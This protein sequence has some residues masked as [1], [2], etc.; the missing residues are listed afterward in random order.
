MKKYNYFFYLFLI[1][2]ISSC[3]E[4]ND[5]NVEKSIQNIIKKFPQ[6][7]TTNKIF[8]ND[9]K[10]VKSVKNGE[11]DFE[12]QL[13][14]EPDIIEDKQQIIVLINS[15]KEC[16]SIPFFSNKYKDYWKFPFDKPINNTVKIGSTFK[17]ELNNALS[18][19]PEPKES[20]NDKNVKYE[21]V[22]EMLQSLLVTKNLE[23]KDSL[24]IYRTLFFN[25]NIPNELSDSV[26]VRLHKN[27]DKM[28]SEWHPKD[29]KMTNYNCYYDIKNG[30]IY[31]LN[32]NKKNKGYNVKCY[33]QDKGFTPIRL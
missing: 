13:F 5:K 25:S 8:G 16:T 23:E 4:K 18:I 2:I 3:A 21:V 20:I 32:Y 6:L 17:V 10:L 1:I 14:S 11:F 26:L 28:K 19:F 22:N 12:I 24:L 27:Y 15:K 29:D 30:R 33:R 7:K 31:Q 9:Y